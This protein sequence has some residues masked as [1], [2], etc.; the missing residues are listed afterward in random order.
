MADSREPRQAG[1]KEAADRV[2][3]RFDFRVSAAEA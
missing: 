3:G 1:K 2:T